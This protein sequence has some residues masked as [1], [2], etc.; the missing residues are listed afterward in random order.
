[1]KNEEL[2][3]SGLGKAKPVNAGVKRA[4]KFLILHFLF[5]A[6]LEVV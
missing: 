4:R 6:F 5:L 3:I 2:K 1:M